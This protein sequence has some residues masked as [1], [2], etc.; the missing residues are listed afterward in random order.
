MKGD[1]SNKDMNI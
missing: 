1:L